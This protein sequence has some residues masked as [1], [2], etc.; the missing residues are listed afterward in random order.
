LA[1]DIL[2]LREVVPADCGVLVPAFDI[3]AYAAQLQRLYSD[4]EMAARMASAGRDFA[5]DFDWDLIAVQQEQ[6]YLRAV[7]AGK[8]GGWRLGHRYAARHHLDPAQPPSQL[9]SV[10]WLVLG[11]Y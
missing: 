11:G 4:H 9:V 2:G 1:F 10:S 7:A 5:R 3:A 6:V 8:E